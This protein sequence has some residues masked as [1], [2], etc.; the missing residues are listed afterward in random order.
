MAFWMAPENTVFTVSILL[1][2]AIAVLEGALTVLGFGMSSFLDELIPG[3]FG[4]VDLDADLTGDMGG[5]SLTPV[6]DVG[7]TSALSRLLGWLFVG[8]VPMLVL[9]VAF[10][11]SFGVAGFVVQAS[12]HGVAGFY[13]PGWIAAGPSLFAALPMTRTIGRGV[14]RIFPADETTAV[15]RDSFVGHVAVITL[16]TATAAQPAQAKL[17]DQH[18]QSHY[19]MV[20]PETPTG[21]EAKEAV[22]ETGEEVLIVSR[23]GASYRAIKNTNPNLSVKD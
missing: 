6:Q 13:L 2:L 21:V 17:Q 15:S 14:A 10:L 11:T 12:V 4:D 3:G 8:K 18:G 20:A 7:S 19:I 22:F 16:G 1:M 23:D 5:E 9:L